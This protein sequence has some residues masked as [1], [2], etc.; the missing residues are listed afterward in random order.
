MSSV[1]QTKL[2]SILNDAARTSKFFIELVVPAKS[3]SNDAQR[4]L[5]II[6]K[7]TSFPGKTLDT[8]PFNYKGRTI[9]L[10]GQHK[11][12]QTWDL[13][14]YLDESHNSRLIFMDWVQGMNKGFESYYDKSQGNLSTSSL[15]DQIRADSRKGL[16][17]L[18][19]K[20]INFDGD[21][22]VAVYTLFNCFPISVSDVTLGSDQVGSIGEFTVS[23]SFSHFTVQSKTENFAVP[24]TKEKEATWAV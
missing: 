4:N 22:S 20:Q 23:F 8:I 2:K 11:Y 21:K 9:P 3:V 16:T 18:N 5:G 15:T 6:C 1:I 17:T 13:T 19:V 7:G 14:F 12:A 10:P 24:I